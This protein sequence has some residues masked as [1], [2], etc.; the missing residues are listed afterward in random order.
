MSVITSCDCEAPPSDTNLSSRACEA[1]SSA[2]LLRL[3]HFVRNDNNGEIY[4][5]PA[6]ERV[7]QVYEEIS[8]YITI[9]PNLFHGIIELHIGDAPEVDNPIVG[10]GLCACPGQ[11]R[12]VAPTGDR[13][14]NLPPDDASI[15]RL[16]L[17]N[18]VGRFKSLTTRRYLDGVHGDNWQPFPTRLWQRN[19][20]EHIIRDDQDYQSCFDYILA[21]PQNWE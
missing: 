17:G 3:L 1:I 15:Q 12:R 19:Y 8:N 18:I 20:Y 11:P 21:N 13:Q 5:C 6:G 9:M 10:A 2:A 16:T 4:P 14:I 7:V